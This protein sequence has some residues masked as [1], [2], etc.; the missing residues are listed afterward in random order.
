MSA[1]D[2][3]DLRGRIVLVTG[4]SSGLGHHMAGLFA[5]AGA[6]VMLAARRADKLAARV[7]ELT[8]A[9][10]GAQALTL[11]V[12]DGASVAAAFDAAEAGGGLPDVVVN[13][14]GVE[15]G[16]FSYLELEEDAWDSVVNTNLKG[17]WLVTREVS[18]RW[19]AAE[20][21]GNVI[22]VASILS[23]RQQKGVTP[24]A[25]SKA[26]LLQLTK[27][28]ALEGARFG[29]RANAIAPGYF[30]SAVSSR[31]LESDAFTEFAKKIP[32]RRA[33]TLEDYEGALLLLASDASA[34]MT[35]Q[36][37][38]IDGGHLVSSL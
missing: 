33:G 32:Q 29:I 3:F 22:N 10:H 9:G 26:G 8:A 38:T 24:Y 37:I 27:Q 15:S 19:M 28:V 5:E 20:Q 6:R 35:G 31:L 25:V 12:T 11:D 36:C 34:H 14:A 30:H 23:F 1:L 2:R 4:A 18:R 7:A 13:N 21:G 17:A 16:A